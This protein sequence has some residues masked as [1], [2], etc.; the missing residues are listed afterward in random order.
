MSENL[1]NENENFFCQKRKRDASDTG[2]FMQF[3][4]KFV[5]NSAFLPGRIIS[6]MTVLESAFLLRNVSYRAL[7]LSLANFV[8]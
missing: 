4:Q 6:Q 5:S 2:N 7:S 8:V 3:S 1:E